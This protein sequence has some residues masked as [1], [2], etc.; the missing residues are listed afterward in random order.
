M[1]FK[2]S[3]YE[4]TFYRIVFREE[5]FDGRRGYHESSRYNDKEECE[6][7]FARYRKQAFKVKY[8]YWSF[9]FGKFVSDFFERECKI[10]EDTPTRFV[11]T[12]PESRVYVT[13]EHKEEYRYNINKFY[14][15]HGG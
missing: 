6:A 2:Y 10:I 4:G 8:N 14:K 12:T 3:D 5:F 7:A 9:D 13:I 11:A 15:A 1:M